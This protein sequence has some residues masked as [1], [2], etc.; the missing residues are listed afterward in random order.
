MQHW[1][2]LLYGITGNLAKIKIL[3]A[4]SQ[5]A[6]YKKNEVKIDLI[7]YSRSEADLNEVR[8]ILNDNSEQKNFLNS[9]ELIQGEYTDVNF[10]HQTIAN[11]VEEQR[12]IVYLALPPSTF[13]NFL[14][15]SCPYSR[16]PIDIIME[17][18]FGENPEEAK[19]LL[20]LVEACKLH[21]RVHFFDHYLFKNA[22]ILKQED[23]VSIKNILNNQPV[24]SVSIKI[25]ESV[26]AG[27]RA[28]FYDQTGAIKDM[29]VH[30]VSLLQAGLK[31][32]DQNSM[33]FLTQA[34]W[35]NLTL[36]QYQS[37]RDEIKNQETT[38]ETYFDLNGT[39]NST[40]QVRF[41]SGKSLAGKETEIN[42]SFD[43]LLLK[44]SLSANIIYIFDT[45][46][47]ET[48]FEKNLEGQNQDHTN[49]FVDLLDS[50][51]EHFVDSSSIAGIW[52]QWQK[53][54]DLRVQN[55]NKLMFY[56]SNF[57]VPE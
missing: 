19:Q 28:G 10:Y 8:S 17:K 33:D 18:P 5:F 50:N 42:I 30:F 6:A 14:Q 1:K 43:G 37:Y 47:D 40:V 31:L 41:I 52:Q 13:I 49:L 44:W 20:D 57:A 15:N 55:Q 45:V 51:F 27:T 35:Q 39:Q 11:L 53:V 56:N 34:Q 24:D 22:A 54:E 26:G 25:L 16:Y 38:T 32:T 12:L 2:F 36:G 46:L 3:P 23:I 4:L 21:Q 48:L 29:W 7:G 9:I